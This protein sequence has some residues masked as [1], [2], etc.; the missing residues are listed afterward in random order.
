MFEGP[1]IL[2]A[3]SRGAC[4][5]TCCARAVSARAAQA[6]C[7]PWQIVRGSPG[8][9][10]AAAATAQAAQSPQCCAAALRRTTCRRCTTC[11][12]DLRCRAPALTHEPVEAATRIGIRQ[13]GML[14]I[15]ELGARRYYVA[16]CIN[17]ARPR[18]LHRARSSRS[19]S[20]GHHADPRV[21][22]ACDAPI[23]CRPPCACVDAILRSQTHPSASLARFHDFGF[24]G[25]K[26]SVHKCV[27]FFR[28]QL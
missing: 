1:E 3:R 25:P 6:A 9:P 14:V 20:R 10:A 15:H 24:R 26:P 5:G 18:W 13:V 4:A 28:N 8:G 22:R 23:A 16:L 11:V 27:T 2:R 7:R 12:I 17:H 19:R 21:P